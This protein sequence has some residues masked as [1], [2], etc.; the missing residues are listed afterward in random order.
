M[1]AWTKICL[2]VLMYLSAAG[3]ANAVNPTYYTSLN[4]PNS[5]TGDY[6]RAVTAD[7]HGNYLINNAYISGFQPSASRL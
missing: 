4:P 2:F 3:A 5:V 6:G 1:K 7:S